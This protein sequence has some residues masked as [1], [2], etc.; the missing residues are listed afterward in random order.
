MPCPRAGHR[1]LLA[2]ALAGRSGALRNI[3]R[4]PEAADEARRALALAL[5]VE[6]GYP[7]GKV[8][9]LAELSWG[10]SYAGAAGESRERALRAQRIDAAGIPDRVAR[11]R[12]LALATALMETGQVGPAELSTEGL[13]QTRADGALLDEAEYLWL[14]AE[15]CLRTGRMSDAGAHLRASLQV[16]AQT[17]DRRRVLDCLGTC[18]HVCAATGRWAEAVTLWAAYE[19]R[20]SD[21][22]LPELQDARRRQESLR[23]A[24]QAL[25]PEKT[26]AAR[27]RGAAMTLATAPEFASVMTAP[28]PQGSSGLAQLSAREQELVI[29]VARGAATDAQIAAQLYISVSSVCSHLDR[30]RD[31][32]GCRRRADLTRLAL[33]AG[34]V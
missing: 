12:D 11:E 10:A 17:G 2:D 33:Q 1:P 22:G 6:L 20:S 13:V 21:L 23:K 3:G 27:E 30:T 8:M 29:L 15:L 24:G 31:K 14:L 9:A 5:A 7:A 34:L 26:Q 25:G 18:G 32:T 28:Q 16:A 4:V 19:A